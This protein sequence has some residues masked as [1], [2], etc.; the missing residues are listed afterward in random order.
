MGRGQLEHTRR[1]IVVKLH[2]DGLALGVRH[3]GGRNVR[4][5]SR[6]QALGHLMTRGARDGEGH[7][8][9]DEPSQGRHGL[10]AL[11]L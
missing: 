6:A 4:H 8:R 5:L 2:D 9:V 7:R 11:H 10:V 1:N 3:R